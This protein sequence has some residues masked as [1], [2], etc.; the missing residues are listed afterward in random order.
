L[1][2]KHYLELFNAKQSKYPEIIKEIHP[3]KGK[4]LTF[5]STL[6]KA[7]EDVIQAATTTMRKGTKKDRR[8]WFQKV[9]ETTKKVRMAEAEKIFA[10]R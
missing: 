9:R 8:E 3:S 7:E 6:Q 2:V 10:G 5:V 4:Y 1:L